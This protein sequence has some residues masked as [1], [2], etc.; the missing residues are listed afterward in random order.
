MLKL[1]TDYRYGFRYIPKK[2]MDAIVCTR[3]GFSAKSPRV[4]YYVD[5]NLAVLS[6]FFGSNDKSFTPLSIFYIAEKI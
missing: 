5:V 1:S 3:I 4:Y 2:Y 6:L